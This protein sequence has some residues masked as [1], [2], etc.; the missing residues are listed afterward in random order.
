[1]KQIEKNVQIKKPHKDIGWKQEGTMIL[2]SNN[3]TILYK[4]CKISIGMW[5]DLT[6]K[7][8]LNIIKKY[9]CM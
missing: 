4:F 8:C 9:C 2:L 1:M 5:K 3:I 6:L 7:N